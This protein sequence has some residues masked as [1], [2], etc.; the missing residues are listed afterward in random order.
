M[1]DPLTTLLIGTSLIALFMFLFLPKSGVFTVWKK[2]K[3]ISKRVLIEDALKHL[4]NCEYSNINC[5]LNSIAGNLSITADDAAELIARLETMGLTTSHE[6]GL[7]L[8]S[9]GRSYALKVIRVHRLW[10]RYLADETGVDEAEWHTVAEELEHD[11]SPDEADELSA[12]IGNPVYDPHG[13]P[14]PSSD[15]DLPAKQGKPLNLLRPGEF[16][17]VIHVEDEPHSIYTQLVAE[18]IY[19]GMQVKMIEV[20]NERITFLANGEEVVLAPLFAKNITIVPIKDEV[21]VK[22][23]FVKLSSLAIGEKGVVLGISKRCR[24]QQR[25]RLMDLGVVPGTVI[26]AEI[27]SIGG[28][29]VAYRIRGASIAL[30]KKQADRIF[31]KEKLI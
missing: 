21:T 25:R 23:K 5:T 29:P 13:D 12:Q 3:S 24:G 18:G 14:I 22:G 16:A 19:Q 31:M 26:E 6:K 1:N 15:G 30:R 28:D 4:Y 17:R 10:E 11:I 20:T 8:T 2:R 7:R 27:K 9:E